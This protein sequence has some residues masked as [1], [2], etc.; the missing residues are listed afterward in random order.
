MVNTVDIIKDEQ[1]MLRSELQQLKHCQLQ[2]FTFSVTGTAAIFGFASPK[3]FEWFLGFSFLIPLTIILPCWW[4]FFDKATTITRIVGYYRVLERILNCYPNY[5][6]NHIGYE[7]ALAFYRIEDD[8][9]G[10]KKMNNSPRCKK[11]KSELYGTT[12]TKNIRH[13]YWLLNW[14][15]YLILSVICCSMSFITIYNHIGF[16]Y[17]LFISLLAFAFVLS[18]A[19][20]T[21]TILKNITS[22]D[23]SYNENYIFWEYILENNPYNAKK[24]L[25]R[26]SRRQRFRT[27]HL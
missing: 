22:G 7:S 12:K 14:Y 3:F 23:Y 2:Y 25:T 20:K 11:L 1:K 19:F 17:L 4:I 18:T 27:R 15:T 6:V 24:C 16:H 10:R 8:G 9:D 26:G 21:L 5:K 13:R